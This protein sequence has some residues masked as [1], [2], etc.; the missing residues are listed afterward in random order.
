MVLR[1]CRGWRRLYCSRFSM[2]TWV[3]L[4]QTW[5]LEQEV[6]NV[7]KAFVCFA[8]LILPVSLR[9]LIARL[10][11]TLTVR[12]HCK[13]V[14]ARMEQRQVLHRTECTEKMGKCPGIINGTFELFD[15]ARKFSYTSTTF[16]TRLQKPVEGVQNALNSIWHISRRGEIIHVSKCIMSCAGVDR[17]NV[18]SA[19]QTYIDVLPH[20]THTMLTG[21][22]AMITAC[23]DDAVAMHVVVP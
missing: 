14:R 21:M 8:L 7:G 5:R 17:Q 2:L 6:A 4:T 12:G 22:C 9:E 11:T 23:I 20:V 18:I 10:H 16:T 1:A 3:W 13:K 15:F 19:P